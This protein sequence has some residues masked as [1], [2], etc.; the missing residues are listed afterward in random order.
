M[1]LWG[2]ILVILVISLVLA[3][4]AAGHEL[5]VPREVS[6]LKIARKKSTSGVILFLRKKIVHY[7]AS[8]SS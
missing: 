4:R 2:S 7:T 6:N 3:I 8:K 5:S 1:I